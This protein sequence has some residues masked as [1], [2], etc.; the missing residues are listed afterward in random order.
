MFSP[1][2]IRFGANVAPA[3]NNVNIVEEA[4]FV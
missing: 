1:P 2:T 3:K 4:S